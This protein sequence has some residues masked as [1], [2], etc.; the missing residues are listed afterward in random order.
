MTNAY[1]FQLCISHPYSVFWLDADV[2]CPRSA[3]THTCMNKQNKNKDT[4]NGRVKQTY[5]GIFLTVKFYKDS[6]HVSLCWALTFHQWFWGIYH[7]WHS[8][9]I[10]LVQSSTVMFLLFLVLQFCFLIVKKQSLLVLPQ[11]NFLMPT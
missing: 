11:R 3:K 4:L 5:A 1:S 7:V 6:I 8:V 9:H 2:E 10:H